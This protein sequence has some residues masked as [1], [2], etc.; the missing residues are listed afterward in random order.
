MKQ[1]ECNTHGTI[2]GKEPS[3]THVHTSHMFSC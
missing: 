2:I 1:I 3:E